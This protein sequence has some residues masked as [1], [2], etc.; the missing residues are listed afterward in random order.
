VPFVRGGF[1]G[2]DVFY[3]ISGFLI[4]ELMLRDT[5]RTRRRLSLSEFYARRARRILPAA[6]VVIVA[7]LAL[8]WR[9]QNGLQGVRAAQDALASTLFYSNIHFVHSSGYFANADPSLFQQFW[10]L[11]LE[12]QFYALWPLLFVG[13]CLV[14]G[15]RRRRTLAVGITAVSIASL[16]Q[17]IAWTFHANGES[18]DPSRAF[19]LLP[20][21]AWELG[22]GALI[23]VAAGRLTAT[24]TAV[25]RALMAGGVLAIGGAMVGFDSATRFPGYAA[26]LPVL[27]AAAVIVAGIGVAAGGIVDRVLA[28][29]FA[30]AVGRYSY[31]LYLWHWP[32]LLL[33]VDRSR[34]PWSYRTAAMLLLTVPASV[35][36]YHLVENPA[37]RAPALRRRPVLSLAAGAVILAVSLVANTVVDTLSRGTLHTATVAAATVIDPLK[38]VVVPSNVVPRNLVPGLA[39]AKRWDYLGSGDCG[40]CTLGARTSHRSMT[41]FGD[42]HA[43]HL[44]PA[45]DAAASKL[46]L[47]LHNRTL[48]ACPLFR[49]AKAGDA[50]QSCARFK[51]AT[52]A[53]FAAHPP[54]VIVLSTVGAD[55]V[56][57]MGRPFM[58]NVTRTLKRFPRQSKLV[59]VSFTPV[60]T[61][62]TRNC[63]AGHVYSA[64]KCATAWPAAL[65]A[66]Y[67]DAVR[68]G[69]ATFVDLRSV[70]CN[71]ITCPAIIGNE[72]V[73][74]D[75][76][77]LTPQFSRTLGPW[78]AE[79]L[80][81]LL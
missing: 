60:N 38:P 55:Q 4:T 58:T 41:L 81:P 53:E 78:L 36:T 25:R 16:V 26:L 9:L 43:E 35:V 7:T 40:D 77:H 61:T 23:A 45:L 47:R 50:E 2:V 12:E 28:T 44:I 51:A 14:G 48:R 20:A 75:S 56:A 67:A 29:S 31:S 65:N 70:L 5:D 49:G 59:V 32:L 63:L 37:R 73:W 74:S 64:S 39:G 34:H 10:S 17:S 80:T 3:V 66:A 42:S 11:S 18:L 62:D 22:V 1:V 46:G 33:I 8:A 76:H 30:Q 19:Y 15:V 68:A 72:L 69:G 57:A 24:P 52:M 79:Q 13:L 21:R 71:G 54:D 27:G 6:G